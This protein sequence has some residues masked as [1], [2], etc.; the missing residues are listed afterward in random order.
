ML[1]VQQNCGKGYECIISIL[2]ARLGL[3]AAV[4]YIQELFLGNQSISQAGFT[5]IDLLEQT[6]GK[7]CEF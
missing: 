1:V 4:V 5:Y 6:T 2:E 7:T 3:D